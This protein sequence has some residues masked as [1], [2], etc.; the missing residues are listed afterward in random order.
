MSPPHRGKAG[1]RGQGGGASNCGSPQGWSRWLAEP[2]APQGPRPGGRGC[3]AG[4]PH[5]TRLPCLRVR[6]PAAGWCSGQRP[7]P[8][9]LPPRAA[10]SQTAAGG[11]GWVG[12][13]LRVCRKAHGYSV[14][15]ARGGCWR[16]GIGRP[17][18]AAAPL[19]ASLPAPVRVGGLCALNRRPA[20]A[21]WHVKAPRRAQKCPRS[22]A[23]AEAGTGNKGKKGVGGL[24]IARKTVKNTQGTAERRAI[25]AK[26]RVTSPK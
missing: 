17:G 13:V 5:G 4:V 3:V 22:P 25:R 14:Q 9:G 1:K 23:G 21:F 24:R 7:D 20:G 10:P 26:K 2:P 6:P 18:G 15:G 16:W 19:A 8:Q 12:C 11:R